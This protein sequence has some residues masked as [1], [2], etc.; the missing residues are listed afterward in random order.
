MSQFKKNILDFLVALIF[1]FAAR[2]DISQERAYNYIKEYKGLEFYFA[3]Y[4][5][6]HTLSFDDN[7]DALARLCSNNGGALCRGFSQSREYFYRFLLPEHR[8]CILPLGRR[9]I[10]KSDARRRQS[11]IGYRIPIPQMG[12]RRSS[13]AE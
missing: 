10:L 5:I 6:M 2:F 13:V 8:I 3:H 1:E 9:I 11:A 12:R 4:N 7:V